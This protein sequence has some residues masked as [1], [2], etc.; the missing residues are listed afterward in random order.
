MLRRQVAVHA[1]EATSGVPSVLC[2]DLYGG[3]VCLIWVDPA[4]GRATGASD[5]GGGGGLAEVTS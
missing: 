1:F 4:T 5:P 2:D 3:R